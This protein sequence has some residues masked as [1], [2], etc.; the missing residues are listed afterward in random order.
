VL[1]LPV[2]HFDFEN[3]TIRWRAE[4]DKKRKTWWSDAEGSGTGAARVCAKHG[5]IAARWC[6]R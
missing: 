5:V 1:N 2:G 4:H 6:S 3:K